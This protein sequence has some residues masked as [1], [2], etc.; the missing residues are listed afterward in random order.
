MALEIRPLI[1]KKKYSLPRFVYEEEYIRLDEKKKK[2]AKE[3]CDL[4]NIINLYNII[5]LL[6]L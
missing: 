2:M 5:I 4:W 3:N 6:I 1:K